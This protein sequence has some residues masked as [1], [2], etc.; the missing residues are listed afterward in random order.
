MS[1]FSI[2]TCAPAK[3][4]R[5]RYIANMLLSEDI[6]LSSVGSHEAVGYG[7][8]R[9][10]VAWQLF[11]HEGFLVVVSIKV[12]DK[13]LALQAMKACKGSGGIALLILNLGARLSCVVTTTPRPLY[14]QGRSLVPINYEIVWGP[15]LVW[16][17]WNKSKIFFPAGIWTP[18]CRARSLVMLP[19]L[20]RVMNVS[21]YPKHSYRSRGP[22]SLFL[23]RYRGD[24]PGG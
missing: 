1:N 8:V 21:E 9:V 24:L 23:N 22:N 18:Y 14:L 10:G 15:E 2:S 17:T 7:S 19:E 5:F 16:T 13:Y 12:K 3:S 11:V 4:I 20:C 6:Y